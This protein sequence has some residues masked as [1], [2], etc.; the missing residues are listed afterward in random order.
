MLIFTAASQMVDRKWHHGDRPMST[1]LILS[2]G[3]IHNVFQY[4]KERERE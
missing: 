1:K 3:K 2:V 4:Q